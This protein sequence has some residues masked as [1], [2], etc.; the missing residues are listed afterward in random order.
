MAEFV[1]NIG[2]E[3]NVNKE[4]PITPDFLPNDDR[5]AYLYDQTLRTQNGYNLLHPKNKD[6]IPP[7]M[8][9]TKATISNIPEKVIAVHKIL[10]DP[11]F[12]NP[13]K[14]EVEEDVS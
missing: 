12:E 5:L 14:E 8:R 6:L 1:R 3:Q 11:N 2:V 9:G 10:R 4:A 7:S 13:D